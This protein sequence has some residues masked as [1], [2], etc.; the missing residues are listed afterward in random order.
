MSGFPKMALGEL[1]EKI[2]DGTH[3]S[4]TNLP[5]GQYKYVTAKNIKSWGLDLANLTYVDEATHR[6][7]YS[8]C[9]VRK[10]DVLYVKDGA[11]TGTACVNPLD[12]EFSLLSSVGVLRPGPALK[13]KY[14]LYA[15]QEPHTK[16]VMMDNVAG[17]A[18]T[19]LTLKK[20]ASAEIFVAPPACQ[21]R[22]V[23]TLDELLSDLDAGVAELQA[24]QKKLTQ[25]RQSLL[26]AAVEGALTAAWR[27][28][29]PPAEP[30]AQLL[31]RILTER[32]ARW[33]A[34]QLDR[35]KSQGKTPPPGWQKKYV[36]PVQPDT[37]GLPALPQGW[38]WAS[39]S[40]VGWLDRG[41]SKHRPRNA[42]HLYGGAYPFVQTGD[43]RHADT[44]L[45]EV[46]A[47]YSDAGLEQSRLWPVGTMC[48]TIAANIGKTAILSMAACFPDS[49][50]GFLAGS[51]DVSIRYVEYFMRSVQQRLEDEAPATAQKNINLEILEKVAIPV[52]PIQEQLQIVTLVD[53]AMSGATENGHA[54]DWALKQSTAQR[55]NILRAA[56]SG[57]LVPQ[58]PRDE[59]ASAL[60]ARIRAER[61]AQAPARKPRGRKTQEVA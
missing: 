1:C 28:Q 31:Q 2:T 44:F 56:F 48:I 51:N 41:R 3:H 58:D 36:E 59:P 4:P 23:A 22:I 55:Q 13:S 33:E 14:L 26:K 11:T 35:F 52:P 5:A 53:D 21:D 60:L 40:Q 24:A 30:G 15:L 6:E 46:E 50:V 32:R 8:R 37:T 18:I 39:L 61:A 12:E 34:R 9:D 42:P 47:T 45:K 10:G 19:R 54:I 25:Y 43:I 38:V 57:Q 16:S 20:L 27:A 29:H 17:V 7:I 49:V